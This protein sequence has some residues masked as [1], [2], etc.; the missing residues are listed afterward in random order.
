MFTNTQIPSPFL[1]EQYVSSIHIGTEST[2]KVEKFIKFE[3]ILA[4]VHIHSH[5]LIHLYLLLVQFD[6]DF[7]LSVSKIRSYLGTLC[8]K[9]EDREQKV[10]QNLKNVKFLKKIWRKWISRL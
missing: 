7:G 3:K 4:K 2:K 8:R 9:T 10:S 1:Y 6:S 5:F